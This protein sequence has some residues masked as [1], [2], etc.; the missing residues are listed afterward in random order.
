MDS[1]GASGYWY[2]PDDSLDPPA[3]ILQ[4]LRDYRISGGGDEAVHPQFDGDG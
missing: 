3:A 1:R 2:G 4:A